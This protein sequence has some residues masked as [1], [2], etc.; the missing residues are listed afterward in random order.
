MEKAAL[1]SFE[2]PYLSKFGSIE[3]TKKTT[4][5]YVCGR[6]RSNLFELQEQAKPTQLNRSCGYLEVVDGT[7][8]EA[9]QNQRSV[10]VIVLD[11]SVVGER[12]FDI[13]WSRGNA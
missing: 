3:L 2:P 7:D 11:V 12:V 1:I 9:V 5:G 6:F 4:A 8:V 13:V 10:V